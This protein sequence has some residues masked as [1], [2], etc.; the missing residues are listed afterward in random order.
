TVERVVEAGHDPRRFAGDLLDRLRD[1]MVLTQVPDAAGKGLIDAPADQ[2][3][4]MAAQAS[5]LGPATLTR[6]AES[7]PRGRIEMRGQTAP[8]L[9]LELLCARMLLPGAETS[10]EALLQRVEQ[11]ERRL[12]GGA[13]VAAPPTSVAPAPAASAAPVSAAPVSAAP[14]SAAQA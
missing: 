11:L 3:E 14:G 6:C 13:V 4:R 12:V 7:V 8:R 5:R 10:T 2:L 9:L 1:L